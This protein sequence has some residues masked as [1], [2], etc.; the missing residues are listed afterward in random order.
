MYLHISILCYNT[1]MH[2]QR[3]RWA[4]GLEQND[5]ATLRRILG[6]S[7]SLARLPLLPGILRCGRSSVRPSPRTAGPIKGGVLLQDDNDSPSSNANDDDVGGSYDEYDS[8]GGYD[9]VEDQHTRPSA[10][11]S[12]LMNPY[13][14]RSAD[15]GA[16]RRRCCNAL[17]P[18]LGF[19]WTRLA[20]NADASKVDDHSEVGRC[21]ASRIRTTKKAF[22]VRPD[23]QTDLSEVSSW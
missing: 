13:P 12:S 7:G 1:C 23:L 15:S 3:V 4:P 2:R 18:N 11:T 8:A 14:V 21:Q 20:P 22:R 5:P 16:R 17:C 9:G 6:Y 19:K 10:S